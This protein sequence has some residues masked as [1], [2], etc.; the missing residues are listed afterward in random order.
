MARVRRNTDLGSREARRRLKT[1]AEP[2]WLVIERGLSIG[3]RRSA[4][5]GAWLVRRY[6]AARRR[7]FEERVATADDFRDPDGADVLDFGRAQRRVLAQ[8]K[9]DALRA[10][11]QRYTVSNAIDDYVEYLRAHRKS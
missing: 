5:G 7:H 2:Y 8:A 10:S 3:Y 6:N 11:G 9:E 1:R 4:E